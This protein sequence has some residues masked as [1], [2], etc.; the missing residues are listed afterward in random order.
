MRTAG[1]VAPDRRSRSILESTG[2]RRAMVHLRAHRLRVVGEDL[3]EEVRPGHAG[4]AAD[5]PAGGE[6]RPALGGLHRIARNV[7]AGEGLHADDFFRLEGGGAVDGDV[8]SGVASALEE[9][10]MLPLGGDQS[11]PRKQGLRP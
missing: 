7:A 5:E 4:E 9:E 11:A 1:R 8:A 6:L 10:P 3:S 2:T